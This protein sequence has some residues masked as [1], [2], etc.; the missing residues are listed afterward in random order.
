MGATIELPQEQRELLEH[1]E[2]HGQRVSAHIVPVNGED[3]QAP[4]GVDFR[5]L[6]RDPRQL[7]CAHM[8]G[9]T[10]P[11]TAAAL[12]AKGIGPLAGGAQ[13]AGS[14]AFFHNVPQ[15]GSY[16]MNPVEFAKH[17]ERNDVPQETKTFA[18]LGGSRIDQRI[19]NVGV[20]THLRL[21][22]VG[23][24]VV[25]T[26]LTPT[27]GWPWNILSKVTLNA[28][29]Q[30][31]LIQCE[32]NDLRARRQRIFRNPTDPVVSGPSLD[33]LGNSTGATIAIGTYSIVLAYE[34]PIVHNDN[35]LTG[36]IFAQSDQSYLQWTAVPAQASELYS[37]GAATLSGTIYPTITFFDIP[38]VDTQQGRIV[39]LGDMQ[40]LHGFL[41][42]DVPFA[43]VGDVKSP[44]IRTAG[45]LIALYWYIAN[46]SAATISPAA[47]DEIRWQYGGNRI[48]RVFNPPSV[49][50]EKNAR[51]YNGL[52]KPSPTYGVLDFEGDNPA[53]DIVLPKGLSELQLVNKIATGTTINANA[54][55]H[56]VEETLYA[57]R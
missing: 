9:G 20:L 27:S 51:E 48:P 24:L 12:A 37:A 22:F 34:V 53:R 1:A 18:A 14:A 17:T 2:R 8:R 42:V 6:L 10:D 4:L 50:L 28:N 46:G 33:S 39:V 47:L 29:G 52:V 26:A 25:T 23:S 36:A 31:S 40:W 49:L 30:T 21:T 32:G 13:G 3:G 54:R 11:Q 15:Q 44:L 41:G 19:S 45:Q 7:L 35:T 16:V 38:Y 43:N 5:H 57:G 55:V 56:M